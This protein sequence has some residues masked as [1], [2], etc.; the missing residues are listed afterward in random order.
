MKTGSSQGNFYVTP[1]GF[2]AR[3]KTLSHNYNL[4]NVNDIYIEDGIGKIN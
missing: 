3:V 1:E 4:D 2:P